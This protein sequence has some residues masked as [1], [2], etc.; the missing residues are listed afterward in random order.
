MHFPKWGGS[1]LGPPDETAVTTE[2]P[3]PR[4]GDVEEGARD[5]CSEKVTLELD[6][7]G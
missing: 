3:E 7:G 5:G 1:R 6:L 4:S 2:H